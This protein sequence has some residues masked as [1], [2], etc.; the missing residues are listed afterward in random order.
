M[1]DINSP[2]AQY[3]SLIIES[4]KNQESVIIQNKAR[5]LELELPQKPTNISCERFFGP[6]TNMFESEEQFFSYQSFRNQL[7]ADRNHF[8]I[9]IGKSQ[10]WLGLFLKAKAL[11]SLLDMDVISSNEF[12]ELE[13]APFYQLLLLHPEGSPFPLKILSYYS[14]QNESSIFLF[15]TIFNL[16]LKGRIEYLRKNSRILP[17]LIYF[18]RG[19]LSV[20]DYIVDRVT[21]EAVQFGNLS[22]NWVAVVLLSCI[23]KRE[24]DCEQLLQLWDVYSALEI[25]IFSSYIQTVEG[26]DIALLPDNWNKIIK[27]LLEKDHKDAV[28]IIAWIFQHA[29]TKYSLFEPILDKIS[30][31]F[32]ETSLKT[33]ELKLL[34]RAIDKIPLRA[35]KLKLYNDLVESEQGRLVINQ[36]LE[37]LWSRLIDEGSS[38]HDQLDDRLRLPDK[39]LQPELER[40]LENKQYFPTEDVEFVLSELTRI[41]DAATQPFKDEDWQSEE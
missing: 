14:T 27:D 11:N 10:K 19:P 13:Q 30:Q 15:K 32:L 5:N 31:L 24:Y 1:N 26:T 29:P 12:Q 35:R 2:Y 33:H 18:F 41:E 28:L 36:N 34:W 23:E 3:I 8:N 20:E 7:I 22:A 16:I 21:V 25:P 39:S 38:I 6:P 9:F 4:L 40:F 17:G 37:K